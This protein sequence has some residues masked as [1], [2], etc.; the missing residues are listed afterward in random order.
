LGNAFRAI[1]TAGRADG[2]QLLIYGKLDSSDIPAIG[3]L[4]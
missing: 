3:E 2:L 1:F 4:A